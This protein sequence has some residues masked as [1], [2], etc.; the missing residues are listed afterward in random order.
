MKLRRSP[1][2]WILRGLLLSALAASLWTNRV[3]GAEAE[4]KVGQFITIRAPITPAEVSRVQRAANQVLKEQLSQGKRPTLIFQ[5]EPGVSEYH[6]CYELADFI[7]RDLPGT[8]RTVAYVPEPLTGHAVMIALAC[9]ELVMHPDAALGDI[10]RDAAVT[11]DQ[12]RLYSSLAQDRRW[13]EALVLGMLDKQL[14]VVEVPGEPPVYALASDL[15]NLRDQGVAGEPNTIKRSGEPLQFTAMECRNLGL[16]KLL[17]RDRASVADQYG[18]PTQATREDPTLGQEPNAVVIKVEGVINPILSGV[19]S[20]GIDR[21]RSQ[22]KNL[23]IFAID[24]PGGL[25]YSSDEMAKKVLSATDV[26][27]VAYIQNQALSGAS[28]LALA[29]DEI[30]MAPN[31]MLGD[32][33][34]IEFR[35][36]KFEHVPEKEVSFVAKRLGDI[37]ESKGRPRALAEAMVDRN[38]VVFEVRNTQTA[39]IR[40]LTDREIQNSEHPEH[41]E[42]RRTITEEDRFLTVNGE[43]AK[44][45][46]LADE[47]LE[48]E[49]ALWRHLGLESPPPTFGRTSID[50]VVYLLNSTT[51]SYL[52]ILLGVTL[53]YVELNIPGITVAGIGSFLCFLLFFWSHILGGTAGWL[54]VVLF[55]AGVGFLGIEIFV[56]PGFGVTGVSGIL[57]IL[58]SIV[59]A[60]QTFVL[61]RFPTQWDALIESATT[62]L[63]AL[64]TFVVVAII[65]SRFL[66]RL[67]FLSGM[68]LHPPKADELVPAPAASGAGV[69][70]GPVPELNGL[71]GKEGTAFTD[72]RPAG[73]AR[74]GGEF[75]DVVAEGSFVAE[76]SRIRVIEVTGNRV[77]VK[78]V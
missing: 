73:K 51:A 68:V 59:L 30:Y 9:D 74:F 61:P 46:G 1:T 4:G 34:P 11:P 35:D 75:F 13:P 32:A 25:L 63:A 19:V 70:T 62:T 54:E 14:E 66:P 64:A 17:A 57:C 41:W 12:R 71:V 58:G 8:D 2:V 72:L 26:R 36:A 33:G 49:E 20:R 47:T 31:A 52:L 21:A 65:L 16:A 78:Q 69:P 48:S 28:F 38:L 18:L 55:L 29:C 60:S 40:Y 5:I 10:G 24:S 77:V 37:A 42:K 15:P 56:I 39:E 50:T 27:T 22:G 44:E 43:E 76:G 6:Q 53:L 45:Y 23:I 3:P 7:R 67:P